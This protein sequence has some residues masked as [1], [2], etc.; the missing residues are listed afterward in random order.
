MDSTVI[1]VEVEGSCWYLLEDVDVNWDF[2]VLSDHESVP[3]FAVLEFVTDRGSSNNGDLVLFDATSMSILEALKQL[4]LTDEREVWLAECSTIVSVGSC[5][6]WIE[7]LISSGMESTTAL[8]LR[9]AGRIRGTRLLRSSFDMLDNPSGAYG[10]ICGFDWL[11]LLS[12]L[13]T[14]KFLSSGRFCRSKI[15]VDAAVVDVLARPPTVGTG[16][17]L[18]AP[19]FL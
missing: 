10:F 8:P 4:E 11:Q 17:P 7:T 16:S 9:S 3:G 6:G 14:L 5:R 12:S 18:P 2:V 15:E 19:P 13:I 1:S